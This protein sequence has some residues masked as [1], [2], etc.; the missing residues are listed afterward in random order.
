[1][2]VAYT[3]RAIQL[4]FF[5]EAADTTATAAAAWEPITMPERLGAGLLLGAT[6]LVGLYP[7]CLLDLIWPSL[8]ASWLPALL[9]GGAP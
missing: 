3:L 2:T 6:V 5:G 9:K 4:A 1:M 8:D 7:Q